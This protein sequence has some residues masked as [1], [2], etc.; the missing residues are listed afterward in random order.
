MASDTKKT[1]IDITQLG[2]TWTEDLSSYYLL[3]NCRELMA[4]TRRAPLRGERSWRRAAPT[5]ILS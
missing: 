1:I 3:T 4:P 5:E 2:V